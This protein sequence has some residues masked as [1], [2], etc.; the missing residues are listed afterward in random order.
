MMLLSDGTVMVEGGGVSKNWYRLTPDSAGSYV[1][2][3]W[4]S[5]ASMGTERLY[6]A[7]NVLTDGRVFVE[8]GEYSGPS[9]AQNVT[10]TGEIYNPVTNTWTTLPTFPQS[11]FGDDPS[12]MLPDGR[13][14]VGYIFGP[15]TYIYNP[16]AN[17]WSTGPTKLFS[18]RSDEETWVKLPDGSI[19]SY[20]IFGTAQH[21]QRFDPVLNQ[22]VDSGSVPVQLQT[23]GGSEL[24]PASLLPDGRLFFIGATNHTAIYTP[25]TTRTGTGSWVAGPD[26]P[27]GIGANDAPGCMMPNGRIL[28]AA[29]DTSTSFNPPTSIFEYDPVANTINPVT[30]SGP[31]LNTSTF[32]T[33][34]L[35]LPSGQVLYNAGGSSQLYAYNPVGSPASSWAPVI[36]NITSNGSG[37][38]T[39]TGTQLN[40]ISEG[41]SYGDDA[42]M[43]S[44]YPIVR[45]TSQLDGTVTFA[46]AFNWSST[47]VATGTTPVSVQFALPAGFRG[48][49]YQAN[50]IANGIASSATWIQPFS[51]GGMGVTASSPANGAVVSTPPSSYVISFS[52]AVESA[53][54][55]PS[56]LTVNSIPADHV[57]LSAD[58]FTATFTY[59]TSPTS[60]QGQETMAIA[61]GA[62][63]KLG[64][65][66]TTIAAFTAS[67]RY[68]AVPLQVASTNP[69][70][71]GTFTLP[72]PFTYDV[73]F[74][75]PINPASVTTAS[76]ILSG[77]TGATVTG[78]SVL[79][80]NTT[81]RFTIG[82]ITTEGSLIVTIPAG[83]VTDSF[84]NPGVAF[85]ANYFPDI[86]TVP[87]PVPLSAE[88]P[89]GSLIYDGTASGV[90]LPAGDTDT[91]TLPVDA[92]QTVAVLVT[93]TS[94][95][96]QAS[97]QLLDPNNVVIAAATASAAGQ[98]TLIQAVPTTGTT[99]GTYKIVVSAFDG[100]S[101]TIGSYTV[102]ATLNAAKEEEG[103]LADATN[104]TIGTAQ[105]IDGSFINLGPA[106]SRGAVL[107][108]TESGQ[109]DFYAFSL[110]AGDTAT[111]AL[112]GLTSG[113]VNV[114]LLAP[115]GA[116]L[117]AGIA[118]PSNMDKIISDLVAPLSGSYIAVISGTANTNYSLV[119]LRNAS[120]DT[121]ANDTIATAQAVLSAQPTGQ[122]RVLGS[123][124]GGTAD[125]YQ[126]NVPVAG[127][128]LHFQT[129]TPGDGAGQP[130]NTLDSKLRLLDASGA[131]LVADDIG[132]ADGRNALLNFTAPSAGTYFIEVSSASTSG[133]YVLSMS[134][135]T[136]VSSIQ[137]VTIDNGT[138]QRSRIRS[139]TVDFNGNITAAPSSAFGLVRTDD[140]LVVPVTVSALTPLLNDKTRVTLTFSGSSLDFGSLSDGHYQ[141]LID[142]SQILDGSGHQVDAAGTGTPGS[143]RTVL[144]QRFFGDANGDGMTDASDFLA[145]RTAYLSGNAT[146]ANSIFD[147]N[148]DG[149]FSSTDLQAFTNNFT[150]RQL[151]T[152]SI[153]AG[154]LDGST[155]GQPVTFTAQVTPI[156]SSLSTPTGTVQFVIDGVDMGSPVT[157]DGGAAGISTSTLA[158]GPHSVRAVYVS[159]D[160]QFGNGS[161]SAPLSENVAPATLIVTADN[162]TKVYGAANPAFTASYA[163]FVNGDDPTV[164]SGTLNWTTSATSSGHVGSYALAV[165]GVVDPDYSIQF[166][167]GTLSVTP[168][169]LSITADNQSMAYGGAIPT[170]TA[171]FSGLVNGD[172][173]AS[174]TEL[175]TLST[176]ATS[177]SPAG[178]YPITAS[179]A[180]D[181]DYTITYTDG[182]ATI[183]MPP[184][185]ISLNA[186]VGSNFATNW[187]NSGPV[188]LENMAQATVTGAAGATGATNILSLTVTLA[189]FHAGDVLS[190]P[191]RAGNT[192]ISAS[193][194]A[195]TLSLSGTASLAQYTQVLRL[196]NYNN[197]AGGPGISP[198]AATFVASDGVLTSTLVT[199][200]INVSVASGQVLGNRLFYNNSKFD[201]NNG[202]IDA[203]DDAAI[204]SDKVGYNGTGTATFSNVSSFTRGITGVMVDLASG[205]GSH[206]LI[207]LTSGDITFKVAPTSFV[208][209]S[210]NQL[211]TWTTFSSE[212]AISVRMGVGTGGSD[213]VEI[214]FANN[215][216]KNTWLEV[217]VHAGGNS[218]LSADDIFYFGS[219][220]GDSGLG[221]LAA[222]AKVDINDANPPMANVLGLTT[223]VF[224]ILDY[225]KDGKVDIN[226]A[227]AAAAGIFTLHYLANPTGPFAPDGGGAAPAAIAT[228][229]A[230]TP[231]AASTTRANSVV[232]SG[233]SLSNGLPT[234]PPSWLAS[235]LQGILSSQP[236]ASILQKAAHD[237]QVLQTIDQIA[238][239]FN[240]HDDVLT[241]HDD[242][243]AGLLADLGLE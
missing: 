4:S 75:E 116:V 166:V 123:L 24:G 23:S 167:D 190:V 157:V 145:F 241:G 141:L 113:T 46:R 95:Q 216:I 79:P 240:L 89:A 225:T 156:D 63:S 138:A 78:V 108:Q 170:L 139:V 231:P 11:S 20:N 30:A 171:S 76:L 163:G 198:I 229:S 122:Q 204:A 213:R 17:S 175:P 104:D 223:Q 1:N 182:T 222:L 3:A 238:A 147:F 235:R 184:P 44:N 207:N 144:F 49:N 135:N 160:P 188:A 59:N 202:A 21:A 115:S 55:Q 10:S 201:G 58:H 107:G 80:G 239:Q 50:V 174:L 211:S 161:T 232:S 137:T 119:V 43:S 129:S 117:A 73:T 152:T 187:F 136:P 51:L 236:V 164:L 128:P 26:I 228:A 65:P 148:G 162:A 62:I 70:A 103:V 120:F 159:D 98:A 220:A 86:G 114:T 146:G 196:I 243:L 45:L 25:S 2:G 106:A 36:T 35:M 87:F 242:V 233:L 197:T 169:A 6:F 60:T 53:S 52:E 210:Y 154:V 105:N 109:S 193:Y 205:I 178:N 27:G 68:D 81:A 97:V 226:D 41:A 150:K 12:A 180:V 15:Q 203:S 38:Y 219:A 221:D 74:N 82:G 31:N 94:P 149:V 172:T 155:Y 168:A 118:G 48:G 54:L 234:T 230:A 134:G 158:A 40:G 14:L 110:N 212:T 143:T 206:G 237:P 101:A 32:T 91:F 127:T 28:F 37:K 71:N 9:G 7:S 90:I 85:S 200:T 186:A 56:D 191:I 194:S 64:D 218:G 13:V 84:G 5:L 102:Q 192:A 177:A 19:L 173:S 217:D 66:A 83:T 42:E 67:F 93:P 33:R 22:W 140:G 88:A 99:S 92:V 142:G 72:G 153:N 34:M 214:T 133:N 16:T 189:T 29:G 18:D 132:A 131:V 61:A 121:E 195:G 96:W 69:P 57:T 112:K 215:A 39:L 100:G 124:T 130:D 77:F 209:D 179:G 208:A 165:S 8:G 224:Q 111:L 199:A 185:V 181:P 227:N 125:V 176:T 47:G 183:N 126:V 151:T